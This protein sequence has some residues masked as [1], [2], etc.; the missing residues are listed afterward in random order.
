MSEVGDIERITQN[1][2]ITLLKN[3]LRYTYLGNWEDRIGNSNIEES[4]LHKYLKDKMSFPDTLINK[5]R[6]QAKSAGMSP[7]KWIRSRC[8]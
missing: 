3:Q 7:S 5:A 1:R 2:V 8:L 6:E 4:I